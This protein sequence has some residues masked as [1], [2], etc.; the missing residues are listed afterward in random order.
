[1]YVSLI[2]Q[3]KTKM[4]KT[5]EINND[6]LEAEN[7]IIRVDSLSEEIESFLVNKGRSV[8]KGNAFDNCYNLKSFIDSSYINAIRAG[9]IIQGEDEV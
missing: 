9:T 6:T 2:V 5:I 7:L 3:Q 1:M 4:K 8:K